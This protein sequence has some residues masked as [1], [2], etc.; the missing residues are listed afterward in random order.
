MVGVPFSVC[1]I[2][3]RI[4]TRLREIIRISRESRFGRTDEEKGRGEKTKS[5]NK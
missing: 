3:L 5:T 4:E 2:P 1:W